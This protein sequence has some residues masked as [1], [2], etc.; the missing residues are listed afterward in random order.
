MALDQSIYVLNMLKF[1]ENAA[2]PK[3]SEFSHLTISGEEAYDEYGKRLKPLIEKAKAYVSVSWQ[4]EE[5]FT[6]QD[7]TEWDRIFVVRYPSLEAF[8]SMI[9]SP[10]YQEVAIHRQAAVESSWAIRLS[11][12][13]VVHADV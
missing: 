6:G 10:E 11:D 4:V 2:Y 9:I 13:Q 3:G 8:Q 12:Q 1:K 5:T 7:N